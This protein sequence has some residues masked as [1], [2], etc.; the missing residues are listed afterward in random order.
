[1]AITYLGRS[2]LSRSPRFRI[3]V[4]WRDLSL[5]LS[6]SVSVSVRVCIYGRLGLRGCSANCQVGDSKHHRIPVSPPCSVCAENFGLHK[7][8]ML[9]RR[10]TCGMID[11]AM[12]CCC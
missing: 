1:M 8:R 9:K 6:L 11:V 3:L 7:K 10:M 12:I 4:R 2:D 5:S